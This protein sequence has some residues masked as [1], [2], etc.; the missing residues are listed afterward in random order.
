MIR[1]P[2]RSTP[3]YSSAAS[4]VYKRQRVEDPCA[5]RRGA[6][7]HARREGRSLWGRRAAVHDRDPAGTRVDEIALALQEALDH[8]PGLPAR[9]GDELGRH[10][11][12][13]R[14]VVA[15][16]AV[17]QDVHVLGTEDE[18]FGPAQRRLSPQGRGKSRIAR[19]VWVGSRT[20]V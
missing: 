17:A 14:V 19:S 13:D 3:L 11:G 10:V 5:G 16:V 6:D 1:L 2:P 4:D 8:G 9:P 15:G 7:R 12:G 20:P 18:A